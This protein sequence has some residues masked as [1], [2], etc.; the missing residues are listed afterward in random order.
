V[1]TGLDKNQA[2]LGVSVTTVLDHVAADVHGLLDEVVEV[3]GDLGSK[4]C[5]A[6]DE[7]RLN[8]RI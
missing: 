3:L 5:V 7:A 6:K 2:E 1:D 4:T 8:D